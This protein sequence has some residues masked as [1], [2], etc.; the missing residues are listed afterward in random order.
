MADGEISAPSP[1]G[2][3]AKLALLWVTN[4][5]LAI[6]LLILAALIQLAIIFLIVWFLVLHK[7]S[8]G[9]TP[10]TATVAPTTNTATKAAHA[11]FQHL[12]S[13]V[14]QS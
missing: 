12:C 2:C 5:P 11:A 6:F 3:C 8:G 10:S 9:E 1:D 4:K 7:G 14:T 13:L